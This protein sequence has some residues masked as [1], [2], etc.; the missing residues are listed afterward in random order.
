MAAD[1][2]A[3][4]VPIGTG[5]E[6]MEAVI[7]IDVLRRA[8]AAVT[9]ASVEDSLEVTCEHCRNTVAQCMPA[10]TA[11]ITRLAGI[12]HAYIHSRVFQLTVLLF[13]AAAKFDTQYSAARHH[14]A[15]PKVD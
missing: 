2:K 7:T 11:C 6:E 15:S 1:Q 13:L 3:V 8:G 5:T 12:A 9:V 14:V 4:L 10:S